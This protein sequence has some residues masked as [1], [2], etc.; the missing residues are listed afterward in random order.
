MIIDCHDNDDSSCRRNHISV[1]A[2]N[3]NIAQETC[4]TVWHESPLLQPSPDLTPYG[5]E[6][7]GGNESSQSLVRIS[8]GIK[9]WIREMPSAAST[10]QSSHCKPNIIIIYRLLALMDSISLDL[11]FAI[12]FARNAIFR[13]WIGTIRLI[14]LFSLYFRWLQQL[15]KFL[16]SVLNCFWLWHVSDPSLLWHLVTRTKSDII[17]HNWVGDNWKIFDSDWQTKWRFR[18]R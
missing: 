13:E 2:I 7:W 11:Y 14:S 5:G 8:L 17:G 6:K 3:V 9:V 15:F 16:V 18:T 4:W 1:I 10:V 12:Y